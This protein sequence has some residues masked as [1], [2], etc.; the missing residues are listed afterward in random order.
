MPSHLMLAIWALLGTFQCAAMEGGVVI[1]KSL[2]EVVNTAKEA[3]NVPGIAVGLVLDGKVVYAKGFGWRDLEQRLP[4]T[5]KT[6]FP[7]ASCTKSFTSFILGQLVEEGKIDWDDP[8][9]KYIPEFQLK[10]GRTSK[11]TIRD[12]I[13]HRTGVARNDVIW[14]SIKDLSRSDIVGLLSKLDPS[15][16]LREKFEYSNFMYMAAGTIIERVSQKSW[17]EEMEERILVPLGMSD[18]NVSLQELKQGND[19]SLPYAEI[20]GKITAIP[21]RDLSLHG[22]S[23]ALNSNVLDMAKWIREQMKPEG[24]K[25]TTLE[26]M[27]SVQMPFQNLRYE[28][29]IVSELGYGLGWFIGEY[30]GKAWIHHGGVIDGFFSEVSL[31][32]DKRAGIVVLT[33]SSTDGRYAVSY[34]RNTIFDR[35]LEFKEFKGLN[36]VD[37]IGKIQEE[38]SQSKALMKKREL[39][40]A[41]DSEELQKFEGDY[42]HPA[43]GTIHISKENDRLIATLGKMEISLIC[44]K[45]AIFEA[46]YPSLLIYG[47]NPI[48]E[49]L[50]FKDELLVPFEHCHSAKP[51]VFRKG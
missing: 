20:E 50:F 4:A 44:K 6:V 21:F 7:V 33:N 38:R 17:E 43:Y 42:F 10:D 28:K 30:R 47:I 23:G 15:C 14:H 31:L 39:R 40:M 45:G 24:I 11:V 37:W 3:F 13:A 46:E 25:E 49:F 51:V 9:V 36:D 5:E 22:A 19:Y 8:V 12:L 34:I 48:I 41:A 18:S 26:E 1:E 2:D 29:Q 35:I 32:P 16:G 27:H